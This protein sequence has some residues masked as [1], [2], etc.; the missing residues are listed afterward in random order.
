MQDNCRFVTNIV[1][2]N[3]R[4]NTHYVEYKMEKVSL[5]LKLRE[6]G[7][8]SHYYTIRAR[9]LRGWT[10]DKAIDTPIKKGNYRDMLFNGTKL[11]TK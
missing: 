1:N 3:N 10:P 9:I 7:L 4:D 6:L 11:K 8:H 5:S 2:V